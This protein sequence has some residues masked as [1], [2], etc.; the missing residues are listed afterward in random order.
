MHATTLRTQMTRPRPWRKT[1]GV[2]IM[3]VLISIFILLVGV[4]SIIAVFPATLQLNVASTEINVAARIA[5]T[6]VDELLASQVYVFPSGIAEAIDS[7]DATLAQRIPFGQGR[8]HRYQY[9]VVWDRDIPWRD[10]APIFAKRAA[11]IHPDAQYILVKKNSPGEAERRRLENADYGPANNPTWAIFEIYR[12]AR[13]SYTDKSGQ[14][15]DDYD[16][17]GD[18]YLDRT[19]EWLWPITAGARYW[20][21]SFRID[22]SSNRFPAYA[23]VKEVVNETTLDLRA[24]QEGDTDAT[25]SWG[26]PN[27]P[28]DCW[29]GFVL[30][31]TG[32]RQEWD[33]DL[34]TVYSPTERAPALNRVYLITGN[35]GSLIRCARA[36]FIADNFR[37]G[38]Y[39]RI[40][41]NDVGRVW[42]PE[43]FLAPGFF[44][45]KDA[46]QLA[47]ADGVFR[48]QSVPG[49]NEYSYACV[50]SGWENDLPN[51]YRIDIFVYRNF[52]GR[53]PPERNVPLARFGTLLAGR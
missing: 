52:D 31:H 32:D 28:T 42:W 6:A 48:T 43:N 34:T 17:E 46:G 27:W 12:G 51:L 11:Q 40:A 18:E 1:R 20:V 44:Y 14:R 53:F 24:V 22:R 41:G 23:V 4:I 19:Q 45:D 50:I 47:P 7:S 2:T 26:T 21:G 29:K 10:L 38:D 13:Q 33:E 25:G 39:I 8:D 36:D 30:I 15:R 5:R 37:Q 9:Y 35:E 16:P 49:A 3:E